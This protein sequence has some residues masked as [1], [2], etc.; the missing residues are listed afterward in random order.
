VQRG[1]GGGR[2][3]S[4][5]SCGLG[6]AG[7][8]RSPHGRWS[9]PGAFILVAGGETVAIQRSHPL[10]LPAAFY[11]SN[12]SINGAEEEEGSDRHRTRPEPAQHDNPAPNG[13]ACRAMHEE[14][15]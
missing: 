2:R 8:G 5:P 9:E 15:A 13:E 4:S 6:P 3:G 12:R 10:S 11:R 1:S 7:P 14:H